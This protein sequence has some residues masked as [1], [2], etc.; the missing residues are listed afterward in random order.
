MFGKVV[1]LIMREVL[2]I[3]MA[4]M[5]VAIPLALAFAHLVQAELYGISSTD[6]LSV[7]IASVFFG[8]SNAGGVLTRTTCRRS[9]P[10]ARAAIRDETV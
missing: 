7:I 8:D 4:G 2:A 9:G 6:P 3:V 1:W 10:I 5:F